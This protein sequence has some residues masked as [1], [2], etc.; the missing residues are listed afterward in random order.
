MSSLHLMHSKLVYFALHVGDAHCFMHLSLVRFI[1]FTL[2]YRIQENF[3][4][5]KDVKLPGKTATGKLSTGE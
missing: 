5:A 3:L 1:L 4:Q 2:I